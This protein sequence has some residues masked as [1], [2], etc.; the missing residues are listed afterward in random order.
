MNE[1]KNQKPTQC[2]YSLIFLL[3]TKTKTKELHE[4]QTNL[5][6][7]GASRKVHKEYLK[8]GDTDVIS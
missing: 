4:D 8:K 7:R 6:E 2:I 1:F 5:S 3:P